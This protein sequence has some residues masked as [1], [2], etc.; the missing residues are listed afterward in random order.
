MHAN[1]EAAGYLKPCNQPE[2][3]R[4][5]FNKYM[6]SK[7]DHLAF[8]RALRRPNRPQPATAMFTSAP[9]CATPFSI[10]LRE[11]ATSLWRLSVRAC[12]YAI[13]L[14]TLFSRLHGSC[15]K[16]FLRASIPNS[17]ASTG[18]AGDRNG[19][20][21]GSDTLGKLSARRPLTVGVKLRRIASV[22][23]TNHI[24]HV[25]SRQ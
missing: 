17:N 11:S 12:M 6:C 2:S 22:P 1:F 10:A 25:P 19:E 9:I 20:I 23:I 16:A 15:D 13:G 14:A 3:I 8:K 5:D 21:S 18:T 24:R 4:V 7:T